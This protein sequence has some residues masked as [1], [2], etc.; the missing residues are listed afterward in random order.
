MEANVYH[1]DGKVEKKVTLPKVFENTTYNDDIIKRALLAEQSTQ[2]QAQGHDVDA[3]MNTSAVYVG[4][5]STYRTGRH[6]GRPARPRQKLAK[7]AQGEVR[8]IPSAKK[9]RRAHPHM[10]GKNIIEKINRKEYAKAIEIAIAASANASLIKKYHSV[11]NEIP[12]IVSSSI[13]KITKAKDLM[14]VLVAL[15]VSEDLERSHKPKGKEGNRKGSKRRYFRSSVLI[16]AK[17]AKEIGKAGR[18]IPGVDV[19]G[20]D[21]MRISVLAPGAKPRL[22]LWTEAAISALPEGIKASVLSYKQ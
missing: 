7:G 15:G 10:V 6:I 9:G 3:G 1:I 19:I 13:E 8:R 14:K 22:T 18:N 16:V 4:R 5:Y 21:R 12:I 11:S 2:Y 20:V 17:D